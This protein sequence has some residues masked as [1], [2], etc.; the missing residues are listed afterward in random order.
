CLLLPCHHQSD[1]LSSIRSIW[2]QN[3]KGLVAG[4]E[5]NGSRSWQ[6]HTNRYCLFWILARKCNYQL[7]YQLT[8][9]VSGSP[10]CLDT[11][12]ANIDKNRQD[13]AWCKSNVN[14]LI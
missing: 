13:H 7:F 11:F 4:A 8:L 9:A 10:E 14:V 1:R 2:S 12:S 3:S 5:L 6:V